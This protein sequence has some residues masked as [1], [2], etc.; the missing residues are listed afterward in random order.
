MPDNLM[1]RDRPML[2]QRDLVFGLGGLCAAIVY[3]VAMLNANWLRDNAA[4]VIPVAAVFA[5]VIGGTLLWRA[6]GK[7][8][9]R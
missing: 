7:S 5:V 9:D 8:P 1:H 2:K 3:F 4:A 6:A